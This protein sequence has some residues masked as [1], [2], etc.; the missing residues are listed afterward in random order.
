MHS[1]QDYAITVYS[2]TAYIHSCAHDITDYNC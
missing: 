1:W 2:K